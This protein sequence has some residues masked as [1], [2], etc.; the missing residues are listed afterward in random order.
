MEG[1]SERPAYHPAGVIF[2]DF[3]KKVAD[4]HTGQSW[5]MA[6]IYRFLPEIVDT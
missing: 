1:S 2:Q 6:L 3:K 4:S 5:V